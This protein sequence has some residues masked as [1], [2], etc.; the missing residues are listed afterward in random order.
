MFI[1]CLLAF[2]FVINIDQ[3]ICGLSPCSLSG[4]VN[5]QFIV[6]WRLYSDEP[7]RAKSLV[8]RFINSS[9]KP[10]SALHRSLP[11]GMFVYSECEMDADRIQ[12]S[13]LVSFRTRGCRPLGFRHCVLRWSWYVGQ[14]S[15][16]RKVLLFATNETWCT[17]RSVGVSNL[18]LRDSLNCPQQNLPS[19]QSSLLCVFS[20]M[21]CLMLTWTFARL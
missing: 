6:Y 1:G 7:Y 2:R 3:Q 20:H 19:L 12:A 13:W 15:L 18:N 17:I 16:V 9:S 10:F 21:G 8:R 4:C 14:Y 11:Y 5:M